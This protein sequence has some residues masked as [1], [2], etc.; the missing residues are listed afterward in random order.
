MV[1]LQYLYIIFMLFVCAMFAVFTA[2]ACLSG[3]Y[4]MM[5]LDGAAA[6]AAGLFSILP[7]TH[8]SDNG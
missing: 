5:A 7:L 8:G 4:I 1:I 3:D 2:F 6:I